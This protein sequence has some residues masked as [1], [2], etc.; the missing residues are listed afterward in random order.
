MYIKSEFQREIIYSNMFRFCFEQR[1]RLESDFS[2]A[3]TNFFPAYAE[4]P[5]KLLSIWSLNTTMAKEK[6]II[7]PSRVFKKRKRTLEWKCENTP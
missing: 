1:T 4:I 2:H 3:T 5:V 7:Q 6:N